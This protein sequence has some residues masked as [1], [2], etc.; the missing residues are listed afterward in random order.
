MKYRLTIGQMTSITNTLNL[1]R[2][3]DVSTFIMLVVYISGTNEYG[4]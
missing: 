2:N 1:I 4:Q 3:G